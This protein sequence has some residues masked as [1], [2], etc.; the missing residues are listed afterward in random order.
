MSML[1]AS[2]SSAKWWLR[3]HITA[4]PMRVTNKPQARGTRAAIGLRNTS[5]SST[6]RIGN[7]IRSPLSSESR[8]ASFRAFTSG[9]RPESS[10]STGG[11]TSRSA[12]CTAGTVFFET[13]SSDLL[14]WSVSSACPGGLRR[15]GSPPIAKGLSTWTPSMRSSR[16]ISASASLLSTASSLAGALRSTARLICD[17]NWAWVSFAAR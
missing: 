16:A 1:S 3:I 14:T 10:V 13:S 7:A 15:A 6:I 8:E 11:R 9:A 2:A 5:R 12:A 17:P 4:I